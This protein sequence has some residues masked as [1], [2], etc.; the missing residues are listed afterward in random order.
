MKSAMLL[1]KQSKLKCGKV[2]LFILC[3]NIVANYD[4]NF[5]I[6]INLKDKRKQM[7]LIILL[8]IY[9]YCNTKNVV[10]IYSN[11]ISD[12]SLGDK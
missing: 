12:T 5:V 8:K 1:Q 11:T 4:F 9:S 10:H 3:L 6:I 7:M 2:I